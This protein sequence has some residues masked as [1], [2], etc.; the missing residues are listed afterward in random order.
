MRL[1]TP[2][3]VPLQRTRAPWMNWCRRLAALSQRFA[4][5]LRRFISRDDSASIKSIERA[6]MGVAA[7]RRPTRFFPRN[8][9]SS[10]PDYG[11]CACRERKEAAARA[12][13]FEWVEREGW[14]FTDGPLRSLT[15]G[16]NYWKE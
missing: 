4:A 2:R 11:P 15:R 5:A 9:G 8:A 16:A 13:F 10:M 1:R 12:E 3:A 6:L 7:S 14:V